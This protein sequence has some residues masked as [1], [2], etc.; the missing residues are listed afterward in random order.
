MLCKKKETAKRKVIRQAAAQADQP[1]VFVKQES[2]GP[3]CF[4]LLMEKTQCPCCIKS[5]FVL[6]QERSFRY[7]RLAVMN[8]HFERAHLKDLKQAEREARITCKHPKCRE[9]GEDFEL[10]SVDHFR[11]HV[12]CVHGVWLR[13][14]RK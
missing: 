9:N 4:P 6:E 3:D 12:Q 5:D 10:E 13:P 11:S 7:C 1:D 8:N 2:P 14:D